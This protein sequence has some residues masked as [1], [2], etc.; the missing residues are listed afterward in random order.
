MYEI[1]LWGSKPGT[2]DDCWTGIDMASRC[3]ALSAFRDLEGLTVHLDRQVSRARIEGSELWIEISGPDVRE[4]RCISKETEAYRIREAA[5]E[6]ADQRQYAMEMGMGLGISAYN[7][8][9]GY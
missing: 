9:M 5:S 6:R 4:E 3:D 8:A 2:N 1:N 7:D